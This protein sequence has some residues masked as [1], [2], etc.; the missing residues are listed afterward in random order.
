MVGIHVVRMIE[1]HFVFCGS[2]GTIGVY[3]CVKFHA[4]FVAFVNHP[5]QRVPVRIWCLSL[6][7]REVVA[8]WFELAGIEGIAF[9][10]YL[11][12]YGVESAA[13]ECVKIGCERSLHPVS[14]HSHVLSVNCLNPRSAK[15]AFGSG[16]TALRLCSGRGK[17]A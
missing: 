14:V 12:H 4:A 6:S 2:F 15:F 16:R 5:L 8:P 10:P 13:F 7:S 3:P 1:S 9:A 17:A 11:K